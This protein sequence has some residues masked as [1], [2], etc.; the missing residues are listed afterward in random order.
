MSVSPEKSSM[1]PR[2]LLGGRVT[3]WVEAC[4]GG[5]HLPGQHWWRRSWSGSW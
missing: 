2:V 3:E 4:S 5:S 1:T